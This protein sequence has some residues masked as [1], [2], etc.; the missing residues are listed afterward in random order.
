MDIIYLAY[1]FVFY[2]GAIFGSFLNVFTAEIE[3]NVFEQ[4][5]N[6]TLFERL[7]RRSHCPKC[8]H[9]LSFF[10][11]FPIFSYILLLGKCLKCRTKISFK[12][13]FAEIFSGAIF[14]LMFCFLMNK[15]GS[16]LNYHLQIEFLYFIPVL[17]FLFIIFF[18]DLKHKVIPNL[19]LYPLFIFGLFYAIFDFKTLSFDFKNTFDVLV[20]AGSIALPIWA[21]Y[22]VSKE[23]AMGGAD[24]KLVF[25][26]GLFFE[27]IFQ[28]LMFLFGSFFIGAFV[29]IFLLLLSR[30]NKLN[31]QVAFGPFI[32]LSFVLTLFLE[33][34]YFDFAELLTF[35]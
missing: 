3:P 8:K 9:K 13:F 4:K 1:F 22:F 12:Y 14:S 20:N 2:L 35:V 29:S 19:I 24:W 10:E 17:S 33:I 26:L 34:S 18:F 25:A 11:L 16:F 27:N 28:E 6:K 31:S 30:K 23:R 15:Y 5:T 21:I 7:N 32:V